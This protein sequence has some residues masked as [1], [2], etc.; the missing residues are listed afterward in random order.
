MNLAPGALR[1]II[2]GNLEN[3]AALTCHQTL[4]YS[5]TEAAGKGAICRGF[6]DRHKDDVPALGLAAAMGVLAEVD[7]PSK[8]EP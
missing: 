8:V 1:S 3:E 2:D 4:P 5:G 6:Y 7:P